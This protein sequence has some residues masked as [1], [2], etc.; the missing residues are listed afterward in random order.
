MPPQGDKLIALVDLDGTLA[1]CAGEIRR[2][3]NV[4]PEAADF[5]QQQA[6][7]AP[8]ADE[9]AHR[10]WKVM[11]EP[12][13]WL[14]LDPIAHG[15]ALLSMLQDLDFETFILTKGPGNIAAAWTEKF[16]WCRRHAPGCKVIIAE[17]KSLVDGHLYVE[18]WPPYLHAWQQRH[19]TG[20]VILP[21]QPWNTDVE[22]GQ[23]PNAIR[24]DGSNLGAV[25]SFA[26]TIRQSEA[27]RRTHKCDF[28]KGS[29]QTR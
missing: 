2:R 22:I 5:V 27:T 20:H 19:P 4:N 8:T 1:D 11:S 23:L 25:R 13:F 24:Y 28:A 21:N 18:D 15:L 14:R 9:I 10:Q 29:H 17:E 12:G 26:D 3:L 6:L 16:A 7:G